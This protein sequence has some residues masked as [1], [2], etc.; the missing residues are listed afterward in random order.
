MVGKFDFAC[1]DKQKAELEGCCQEFS[2]DL[3]RSRVQNT[4]LALHD[5]IEVVANHLFFD[6]GYRM[7]AVTQQRVRPRPAREQY[8]NL[9][10]TSC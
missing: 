10:L 2:R 3:T 5:D 4:K 6:A 7:A 9:S 1:V 8:P